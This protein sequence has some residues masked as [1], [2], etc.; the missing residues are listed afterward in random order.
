[1]SERHGKHHG[2]LLERWRGEGGIEDATRIEL[3]ACAQCADEARELEAL[4]ALLDE[5]GRAERE[6]E[7]E[8]AHGHGD[9]DEAG[10]E[11]AGDASERALRSAMQRRRPP[12]LGSWTL[13][14]AAAAVAGAILYL[15]SPRGGD[16]TRGAPIEPRILLGGEIEA[17]EPIGAVDEFARFAW[18]SG[19]SSARSQR[20]LIEDASDPAALPTAFGPLDPAAREW[21]PD[22]RARLALP[23]RIRW[24]VSA[25][26]ERGEEI[27]SSAT[28][29]AWRSG[30]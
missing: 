23:E 12:R 8:T 28:V 5:A 4:C 21:I 30:R 14:V 25:R 22:E 11:A 1:M 10:S 18:R 16:D 26:D 6:R 7:R 20:I 27:G 19:V 15:R 9:G 3:L 24:R 2:E 29:E 13:L 17:L